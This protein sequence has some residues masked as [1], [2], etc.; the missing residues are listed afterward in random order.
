MHPTKLCIVTK[1]MRQKRKRMLLRHCIPTHNPHQIAETGR[2][3]RI[4][5]LEMPIGKAN[6]EMP[7]QCFHVAE[8]WFGSRKFFPNPSLLWCARKEVLCQD[9]RWDKCLEWL[10]DEREIV[11]DSI[12]NSS[13]GFLGR[14]KNENS[15][16]NN[17]LSFLQFKH[18]LPFRKNR[19][20]TWYRAS[21]KSVW[22]AMRLVSYVYNSYKTCEAFTKM[23]FGG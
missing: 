1:R 11:W 6:L 3:E 15:S 17:V 12:P 7:N 23:T 5:G 16:Q 10:C 20:A 21:E 4:G 8:V 14:L 19:P 22:V 9:E 13:L 18:E 2:W